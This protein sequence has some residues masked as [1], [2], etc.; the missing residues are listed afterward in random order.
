[1]SGV[2]EQPLAYGTGEE[3]REAVVAVTSHDEVGR[4]VFGCCVSEFIS[5]FAVTDFEGPANICGACQ[6]VCVSGAGRVFTG[7]G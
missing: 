3:P 2:L 4:G 7:S 6:V 1:M 5:R